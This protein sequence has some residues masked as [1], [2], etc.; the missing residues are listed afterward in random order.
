MSFGLRIKE[1]RKAKGLTQK[2]LAE[3]VC[4]AKATISGYESGHSEPDE[5]RIIAIMKALD[6]DA[7]YLWQDSITPVERSLPSDAALKLGFA[8]DK[9]PEN[10]QRAIR[11]MLEPYFTETA[12]ETL[13]EENARIAYEQTF[14]EENSKGKLSHS[15][16]LSA[17]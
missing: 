3:L 11:A 12:S 17:G 14:L 9:A 16:Y 1:A 5:E 7:N 6:V 10:M 2:Q 4:V 13:A 8:F 15:G